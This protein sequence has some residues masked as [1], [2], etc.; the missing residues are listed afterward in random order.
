[1]ER[2]TASPKASWVANSWGSGPEGVPRH[3]PAWPWCCS[4]P[5]P[6]RP[7][8]HCAHL[9]GGPGP[10][11]QRAEDENSDQDQQGDAQRDYQCELVPGDSAAVSEHDFQEAPPRRVGAVR[12]EGECGSRR[13]RLGCRL[14]RALSLDECVAKPRENGPRSAAGPA[15]PYS[16]LLH[17]AAAIAEAGSFTQGS[18]SPRT[19]VMG[20]E[21]RRP[22]RRGRSFPSHRDAPGGSVD[23]MISSK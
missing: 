23:R 20:I 5:S 11:P 14:F 10:A 9:F 8:D 21:K 15:A 18:G 3:A 22:M 19:R 4:R 2:A 6:T 12:G 13:P 17:Q 1:V 16:D 7:R